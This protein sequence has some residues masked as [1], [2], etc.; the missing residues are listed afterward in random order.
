MKYF[1]CASEKCASENG[2][3]FNDKDGD[4]TRDNMNDFL[5]CDNESDWDEIT[6]EQFLKECE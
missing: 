1:K 2:C 3:L 5:H 4:M 6:K